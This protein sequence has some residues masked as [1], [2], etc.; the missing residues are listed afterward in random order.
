MLLNGILF[1]LIYKSERKT[2]DKRQLY[3]NDMKDYPLILSTSNLI[4]AI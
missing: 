3:F 4:Q 1:V 2:Y